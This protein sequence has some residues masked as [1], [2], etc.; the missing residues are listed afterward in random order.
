M[1]LENIKVYPL[2]IKFGLMY[3]E[4]SFL[5]IDMRYHLTDTLDKIK[6]K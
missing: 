4:V 3:C 5:E 1:I 6:Q 2:L